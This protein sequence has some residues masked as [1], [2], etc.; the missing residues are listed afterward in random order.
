MKSVRVPLLLTFTIVSILAV[1]IADDLRRDGSSDVSSTG[2]VRQ[3]EVTG[4]WG[5]DVRSLV[6]SPDNA[7]LLYLGT[8]DG[9]I[10]RSTDGAASWHRLKPGLDRRGLSV[11]EIVID[12]RNT[13]RIFAGTWAVAQN[14]LEQGVFRTDDG[15]QHWQLLPG[16]QGLSILSLAIAPSDS[17][18]LIAGAKSGVFRTTDAGRTW[19]R[20][21]PEGNAELRN[22]NSVAISPT[23][24]KNIY[25]GTHHLPWKTTDGGVTWSQTGYKA[26]GMIDDT[27]IM[28][29]CISPAS[30]NLVFMNGCS[31]I[32]RSVN[33]GDKWFKIPGIPF[34]ARR[35]YALLTHPDNPNIIFAGTSEGL[36]R[37]KDGGKRWMLLTSKTVVIRAIVVHPDKPSRVLIATDDFGVRISQNLGDDFVDAN[38]GFFHRHILA[39]EPDVVERG[40]ILASVFHDGNAGSVFASADGGENW[41]PSSRGLGPRDVFAFYQIPD[42][43]NVVYA[44]TNNGVFRSNDRGTSWSFVGLESTKSTKPAKRPSRSVRKKKRTASTSNHRFGSAV[45]RYETIAVQRRTSRSSKKSK[46]ARGKSSTGKA[47]PVPDV[48]PGPP[49]IALTVQVDGL[50]GFVT[51]DG[52]RGLLAATMD[53]LYRT[54][55]ET[56]GWERIT[57]G[58]Y[59]PA[60]RAYSVSTHPNLP[61]RIYVGTRTGLYVSNDGCQSF[62][63]V[64]RGPSDVIVKSIAQDPRDPDLVLL[65]TNQSVFRSTNGGRTWT[66]R[67]GGLPSGDF[68]SIVINPVNPD[69]VMLAEYSR[70]GIYRSTDRGYN[71][72]RIDKE[73]PSDRVWILTFDPFEKDKL[74]AGSFSGGV[75]V[76]TIHRGRAISSQ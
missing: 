58:S 62:D 27:D 43:P 65:G 36:W 28:G 61:N 39:I 59:E 30:P 19:E 15:G 40:R 16:T 14:D 3:W 24:T 70:G 57:V 53:G 2:E 26:V 31:G 12:P 76:L 69:E 29:I 37:T 9:Q 13:S 64:E 17:N 63:H 35:T 74:Y 56:R 41:M 21:S 73:L 1:A 54:F 7:D 55:D 32:Y 66:R 44:G 42:N 23:D 4:P 11:D 67:G 18:L 25:I 33:A 75:Y 68:T 38:T 5:G 20:L 71:W 47:T 49:M 52:R 46:S 22:I 48:P 72:E 45:N 6:V 51:A 34:S 8:S 60:G 10:F 50:T